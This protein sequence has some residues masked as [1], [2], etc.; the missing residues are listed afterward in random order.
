MGMAPLTPRHYVVMEVQEN[1]TAANRKENLKRFNLP[2]FKK[3]A[4][5]IMGEPPSEHKAQVHAQLLSDKQVKSDAAWKQKKLEVDRK[6]A[7]KKKQKEIADRRKAAEEEAKRKKA[8]AEA[9]RKEV[10]EA[11][12]KEEEAKKKEEEAKKKEEEAK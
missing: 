9:K 3:V 2:H 1:L 5:V 6:K 11:K 12:K 8:E 10:E 4:A 7:I